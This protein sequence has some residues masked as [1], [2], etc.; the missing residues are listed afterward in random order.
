MESNL[1]SEVFGKLLAIMYE[2]DVITFEQAL[3]S[4]TRFLAS[5]EKLRKFFDYFPKY[6]S[7]RTSEWAYCHRIGA[8]INTNMSIEIMHKDIKY[9]YFHA[10]QVSRMD[11][12]FHAIL[13]YLKNKQIDRLCSINRG[14]VTTKDKDLRKEHKNSL[15]L[16][17]STVS[18]IEDHWLVSSTKVAS[19]VYKIEA[20][21]DKCIC[22]TVC[23]QCMVCIH[24]FKCDCSG[25]GV[26]FIMC[27]HIHLLVRFLKETTN[28]N[29][30]IEDDTTGDLQIDTDIRQEM[31][32]AE[33]RTHL[34]D[35]S[36]PMFNQDLEAMKR[37]ASEQFQQA[38]SR[39]TCTTSGEALIN[40]MKAVVA[41]MDCYLTESHDISMPTKLDTKS[42]NQNIEKQVRLVPKKRKA[43]K[44][45]IFVN[46][47]DA[48]K[49]LVPIR[50]LPVQQDQWIEVI[51][52]LVHSQNH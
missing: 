5:S 8:R 26:K 35:L 36:R 13:V 39:V 16:D 28:P 14:K 24:S 47:E 9:N 30:E 1:R 42:P 32:Q 4:F 46:T 41:R 18:S 10:K 51:F 38:L 17:I 37:S 40:S 7:G 19:K 20:V 44:S 45:G 29:C 49:D 2:T 50:I 22:S 33:T 21:K 6:Y 3:M 27:K 31:H 12:S 15:A 52:N 43:R 34:L 11:D 48:L 23:P 25:Y